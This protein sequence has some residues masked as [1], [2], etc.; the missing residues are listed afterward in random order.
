MSPREREPSERAASD[1]LTPSRNGAR[2]GREQVSEIQRARILAAMVDVATERGT[3]SVTVAR[4]V[5]RSGVSRR[6]FYELFSDREECFLAAFDDAVARASRYV[7]DGYDPSA[8]WAERIRMALTGL[9]SFLD[10]ERGAG[11]LLVVGSLGAGAKA[12]ERRERV[13]AQMITLVEE[14]GKENKSGSQLPPLTAEGV[15]G[16]VLSIL[17]ARL[18]QDDPGS[19]VELTGPLMSMIVLPYL[20]SAAARRELS[21]PVPKTPVRSRPANGDPL[22]D[23]EMRLTY[24]TPRVLMAIGEEGGRGSYLSNRQ[25]GT[26]AGIADQGQVSKLLGRLSRL[27]LVENTIGEVGRGGPNAWVLTEKGQEIHAVI[28]QQ[29]SRS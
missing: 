2:V 13:L 26:A 8:R 7:L 14:G 20:G 16:G 11:R 24:R 1:G 17:H 19:L 27:G 18:L 15:V 6:T 28:S 21:K 29:T 23:L 3:A 10:V 5:A 9:L 25:V 4:V 12:F 22:K